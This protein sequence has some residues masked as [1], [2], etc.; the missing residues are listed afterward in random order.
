MRR[1][2]AAARAGRSDRAVKEVHRSAGWYLQGAADVRTGGGV[3][4]SVRGSADVA[5]CIDGFGQL[6]GDREHMFE[7][8]AF[9]TTMWRLVGERID[10]AHLPKIRGARAA[11]RAAGATSGP[12]CGSYRLKC[13]GDATCSDPVLLRKAELICRK[14]TDVATSTLLRITPPIGTDG[15]G[16]NVPTR[17]LA[18]LPP[19]AGCHVLDG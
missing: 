17:E 5:D 1:D 15:P 13:E 6:C 14:R 19:A 10:A 7:V 9:T 8:E 12:S 2:E 3:R 11:A 18:I 16:V 4:R